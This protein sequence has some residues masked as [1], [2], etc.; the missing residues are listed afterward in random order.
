VQHRADLHA[1]IAGVFAELPAAEILDRLERADIACARRNSVEAFIN[2]PQL[3]DRDCWRTIDSPIG[4]LRALR[5]PVR[6]EGVDPVM[7]AVP[8]LGQHSESI[9]EA[10]GFDQDTIA[11]WRKE[12]MI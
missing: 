5:P 9:L 11:A 7:G 6:M 1:L 10:L 2:H 8:S 3:M 4:P 12:Q